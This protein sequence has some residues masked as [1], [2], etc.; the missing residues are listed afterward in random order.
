MVSLYPKGQYL[1]PDRAYYL[2]ISSSAVILFAERMAAGESWWIGAPREGF[3]ALCKREFDLRPPERTKDDDLAD[4]ESLATSILA[5]VEEEDPQS[6][7]PFDGE[8][9]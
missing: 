2:T 5:V 4:L 9:L 6:L 1:S 3:S 8:L 7:S